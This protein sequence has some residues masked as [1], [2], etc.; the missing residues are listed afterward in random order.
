MRRKRLQPVHVS[1]SCRALHESTLCAASKEV[2]A[3][4]AQSLGSLECLKELKVEL[5]VT[6]GRGERVT[7]CFR[8][9]IARVPQLAQAD[10][11]FSSIGEDGARQLAQASVHK[12]LIQ[13]IEIGGTPRLLAAP[14]IASIGEPSTAVVTSSMRRQWALFSGCAA[15]SFCWEASQKNGIVKECDMIRRYAPMTPLKSAA[16]FTTRPGRSR[17][18]L[19]R[20]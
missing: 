13:Q 12:K 8:R 14:V 4:L 10:I 16:A 9:N 20:M 11:S 5:H 1:W 17:A 7:F 6:C 3:A 18:W 19:C 2:T 15:W